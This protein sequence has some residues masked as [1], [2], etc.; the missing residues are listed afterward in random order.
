MNSKLIFSALAMVFGAS[1]VAHADEYRRPRP[2]P[3]QQERYDE[4]DLDDD[5]HR[6]APEC[7][8]CRRERPRV[9]YYCQPDRCGQPQAPEILPYPAPQR[10]IFV[11]VPLPRP[12]PIV[13]PCQVQP[14]NWGGGNIG[15]AVVN[16]MGVEVARGSRME[17]PLIPQIK[18]NLI[19]A[20]VCLPF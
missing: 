9:E 12:M 11:P 8:P 14:R 17:A 1:L 16:G 20:G 6:P 2:I 18:I 7:D 3:Q 4:D 13:G 10:P 15:W 5:Y 19:N